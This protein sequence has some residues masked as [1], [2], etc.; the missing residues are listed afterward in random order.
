MAPV[1]TV[2]D[3]V[4]VTGEWQGGV[5]ARKIHIPS[6]FQ[7]GELVRQERTHFPGLR[8]IGKTLRRQ[9]CGQV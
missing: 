5:V 2:F 8:F 9:V 1:M 6:G 4:D 7:H 3:V